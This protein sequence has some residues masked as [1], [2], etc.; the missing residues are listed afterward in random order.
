MS[1]EIMHNAIRTRFKDQIQASTF[2]TTPAL[3][4][5]TTVSFSTTDDSINDAT[6]DLSVFDGY[7]QVCVS[8][9]TN[10][11]NNDVHQ[12]KAVTA[13]KITVATNLTTESAGSS[14]TIQVPVPVIYD[15]DGNQA[16]E[17]DES[18]IRLTVIPGLTND[19]SFGATRTERTYG[20]AIAQ[21]F[22]P[23]GHGDNSALKIADT[24][25]SAFRSTN[26]SGVDYL[27]PYIDNIG[28]VD[29]G[30][31]YQVNVHIPFEYDE[32]YTI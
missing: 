5:K 1:W 23:V 26:S 2:R 8:G 21:V 24:I 32:T 14:V 16:Y 18:F 17:N 11:G 19:V 9:A 31:F 7:K 28:V 4:T 13:D 22:V 25:R 10:A 15:N 20:V 29:A 12:I 27:N 30:A 6:E 3:A